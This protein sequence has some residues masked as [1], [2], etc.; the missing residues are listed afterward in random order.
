MAT[1][2]ISSLGI[3]SGLDSN[4]IVTRLMALER[5]PLTA[6][7][8]KES[9]FSAKIS[10][11]GTIKSRLSDLQTAATTLGDPNK[12]AAFKATV[13]DGDII[14]ASAGTF[15]KN[16]SYAIEVVQLAK[17][18][19]S[20]SSIQTAGT[21]YG[22]GTLS[23]SINGST[24]DVVLAS[25][26]NSLQD[27]ANAINDAG[28]DVQATVVTG[29]AGSRL[30]LTAK[31][32]GTD[33]AFSLSVSGGDANL[34]GLATFDGAH[35][36]ASAALDSIITVEGETV[37]SQ[38]NTVTSAIANVTIN[39]TAVGTSTLDV[40]RDTSG[41]ETAVKAFVDAY[42]SLRSDITAKTAYN[43]E[44]RVGEPLNGDA[45][46]RTLLGRMRDT[47]SN[48]PAGAAGSDYQY[49]YTLGVSFTQDGTLTFDSTKLNN[50]VTTDFDG[51]VSV[52]N[53]YGTAVNDMAKAFT[54]ADGLI[55]SRVS[56]IETSI[57]TIDSQRERMERQFD[58]TEA[59]LRAQFTALD[60]LVASLNTTSTFLSQ[61]L[62][63]L[64]NL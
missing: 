35:P 56:G 45:T 17:A 27:V 6:L 11:L 16:G 60:T 46:I 42:N 12:L 49:L 50:A 39:A 58:L 52:L 43:S 25:G 63:S 31:N 19:K 64:S 7:N 3:G 13:G 32:T 38:S 2:S 62:E 40:A 41:I 26:G 57:S 37:T 4:N 29:D 24:Q 61:Q 48:V 51:V 21:S 15:A 34:T 36:N 22:A 9:S 20:F 44:T 18:Q 59:R 30:V 53:A 28:I 54:Q 10:A 33:N 23:F 14:S 5:Q 1:G 55:D 47:L 8:Q